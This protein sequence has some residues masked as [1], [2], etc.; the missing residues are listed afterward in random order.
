[1]DELVRELSPDSRVLDLGAGGGSFDYSSTAAGVV[2]VDLAFPKRSQPS[3]GRLI[4]NSDSLPLPNES[5]DVVVCNHTLEHFERPRRAM[6]EIGRVLK[7][8]G[9]VWIAVP[10]GFLLDDRLY[11]FVFA[12]GGHVNR[13]SLDSL[14]QM[15]RS[16]ASL[17]AVR[18]KK[19]HT[20]F[21][22]LNPPDPEKLPHYPRRA[23]LLAKVPPKALEWILRWLNY[24]VRIGDGLLGTRLSQ[25]GWG[26]VFQNQ[27][28]D[29]AARPP[30]ET[31]ADKNVCFRCGAG[32]PSASLTP[33]LRPL[34]FWRVYD[35]PCC[36]ARNIFA[37]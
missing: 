1:M 4:G 5:I 9:H 24:A 30:V 17:G 11:R 12:G 20:G 27:T 10:D 35:C 3:L 19:L 34:L 2:A 23:R 28:G 31:P 33:L 15:A 26:V 16:S 25:Y 29:K 22:Y 32:H 21:V 14:I 13:F 6:A 36:G 37:P 8:G 18:F 7:K